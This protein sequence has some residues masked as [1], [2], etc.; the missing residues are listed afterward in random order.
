M[1]KARSC[2]RKQ[3][4]STRA[5]ALAHMLSLVRD[6]GTPVGAM[7]VYRCPYCGHWHVGHRKHTRRANP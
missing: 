1:T 5:D 3:R 7:S 2:G 4:H 6:T